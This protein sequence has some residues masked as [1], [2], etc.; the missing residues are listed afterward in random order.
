MITRKIALGAAAV[1][2]TAMVGVAVARDGVTVR[3]DK[4]IVAAPSTRVTATAN[5]ARVRVRAPATR[6]DVDTERSRV[7]VRV[8][9]FD[10]DIRW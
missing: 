5:D 7:H 2:V 3:D 9:F 8:P 1:L 6:V 10:G 4:T